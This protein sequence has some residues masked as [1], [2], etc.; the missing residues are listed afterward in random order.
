MKVNNS[1]VQVDITIS[2]EEL[3]Q[4]IDKIIIPKF[5][6]WWIK[7]ER[8]AEVEGIGLSIEITNSHYTSCFLD[9]RRVIK[10]FLSEKKETFLPNI[11]W[12]DSKGNLKEIIIDRIEKFSGDDE[13]KVYLRVKN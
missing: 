8:Y 13:I 12:I 1:N 7:M 2:I 10:S 6:K 9:I 5:S 3:G 11:P 4:H